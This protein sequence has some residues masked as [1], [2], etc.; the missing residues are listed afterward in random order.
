MMFWIALSLLTVPMLHSHCQMP[1]G[2]YHDDMVFDQIDQYV[3]T[4]FKANTFIRWVVKKEDASNEMADLI[5]TYFLQQ[6]IKPDEPDTPKRL[7]A[8]HKMLNLLMTIKQ[9]AEVKYVKAFE[10]EWE[11]FKLF[12]HIE[13]YECKMEQRKLREIEE[14]KKAAQL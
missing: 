13:G 10:E 8:A 4:M 9:T 7:A 14:K 1:C 5:T 3:E 12:F 2:I 11:K 6:K